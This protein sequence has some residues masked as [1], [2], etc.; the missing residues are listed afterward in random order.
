MNVWIII[1]MALTVCY[2][3]YMANKS[4]K[5]KE[6]NKNWL[7]SLQNAHD[8]KNYEGVIKLMDVEDTSSEKLCYVLGNALLMT[9]EVEKGRRVFNKAFSFG[10]KNETRKIFGFAELNAGN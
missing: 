8:T 4:E 10:N 9:G 6:A 7:V 5:E 3:I 1:I 2:I